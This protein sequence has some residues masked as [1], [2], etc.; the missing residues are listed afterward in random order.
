[1]SASAELPPVLS[2]GEVEVFGEGEGICP[3]EGD[4]EFGDTHCLGLDI[5]EPVDGGP[6]TYDITANAN[7]DTGDEIRYTFTADDGQ[8]NVLTR[9]PDAA[10]F[11][12]F[13]LGFGT[14]TITVAVDDSAFCSDEANNAT[15]TE[16]I[17]IDPGDS[18]NVALGKPTL[19]SSDHPAGPADRGVDG[20]LGNFTHT[21]RGQGP[22]IWEVD[23]LDEIDIAVITLFYRG[24][25]CCQSRLRDIVVSIHDISFMEDEPID[26]VA[27]ADD[28][29]AVVPLWESA[30][31]ESAVLNPENF[32]GAG[33]TSA[34]P[35]HTVDVA[36]LA[37]APVAGQYVR[38]TRIP[39]RARK[40]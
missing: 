32:W 18:P 8:G 6:G 22:A 4:R 36:Q 24:G 1:M 28:P 23:L 39:D 25:G 30:I 15:C 11:A 19:Q 5:L 38:I 26:D 7:D 21:Q 14:W 16:E 3:A 9:G 37:G 29:Q 17:V 35:R 12:S 34:P 40:P 27:L 2:L 13:N 31:W 20:N 10:D 33:G